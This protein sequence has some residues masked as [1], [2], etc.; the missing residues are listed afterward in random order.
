MGPLF[1]NNMETRRPACYLALCCEKREGLRE[2]RGEGRRI[3]QEKS[4]EHNVCRLPTCSLPFLLGSV[5]RL[6]GHCSSREIATTWRLR[7]TSSC[8]CDILILNLKK[9]EERHCHCLYHRETM[10]RLGIRR[11]S[12]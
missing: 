6:V 9:R 2:E 8:D 5:R 12:G 3:S 1:V 4:E 7:A 10:D 11:T